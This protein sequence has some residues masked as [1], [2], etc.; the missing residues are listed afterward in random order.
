MSLS[1]KLKFNAMSIKIRVFFPP[2]TRQ[3][4]SKVYTG[5]QTSKNT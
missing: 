4:D 5:K 3:A 2:R 1:L